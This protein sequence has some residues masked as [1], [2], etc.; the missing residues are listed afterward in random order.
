[1][2]CVVD[3]EMFHNFICVADDT[4]RA[5]VQQ[6]LRESPQHTLTFFGLLMEFMDEVVADKL[7]YNDIISSV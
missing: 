5:A 1:M 6:Q 2:V 3:I 4:R 7:S